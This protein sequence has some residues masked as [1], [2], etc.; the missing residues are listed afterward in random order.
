[1]PPSAPLSDPTPMYW[2]IGCGG[3]VFLRT[4]SFLIA[5]QQAEF[6]PSFRGT[7][8][9]PA[10]MFNQLSLC[11]RPPLRIAELPAHLHKR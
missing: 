10:H 7:V 9:P 4:T 2:A 11:P 5:R 3:Q 6:F 1:M 8:L